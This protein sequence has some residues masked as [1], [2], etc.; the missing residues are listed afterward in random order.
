VGGQTRGYLLSSNDAEALAHSEEPGMQAYGQEKTKRSLR[1]KKLWTLAGTL[2]LAG[3][4]AL[5]QGGTTSPSP[6]ATAG[7]STIIRGCLKGSNGDYRLSSGGSTY[8]LTGNTGDLAANVDKTV[9]LTG[10]NTSDQAA[11]GGQ[12][13]NQMDFNVQ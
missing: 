7:Q 2:L 10:T 6:S 12:Q 9:E 13:P 5:A 8:H 1:M 3:G 4:V 11:A